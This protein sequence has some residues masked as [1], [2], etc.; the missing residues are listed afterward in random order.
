MLR[1]SL[2]AAAMTLL[3]AGATASPALAGAQSAASRATAIVSSQPQASPT[4]GGALAYWTPA[5]LRA[6]VPDDLPSTTPGAAPSATPLPRGGAPVAIPGEPAD[7]DPGAAP[8]G[9]ALPATGPHATRWTGSPHTSPASTTGRIFFSKVDLLGQIVGDYSCSGS[10][11]VSPT[12]NLVITAGHCV[13]GGLGFTWNQNEIFIPGYVNGQAPYGVWEEQKMASLK[14]WTQ[15]DNRAADVGFVVLKPDASGRHVASVVGSNGIAWNEGVG[16]NVYDFGYPAEAPFAGQHLYYCSGTTD[17]DLDGT[18]GLGCT[19]NQGSSG[20]PWLMSFDG[21][22]G[23]VNSVNSYLYPS[24]PGSLY[25][26]WFG[27]TIGK[28]YTSVKG[29]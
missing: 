11:V 26:P 20:G 4:A 29:L 27:K 5:R 25:G 2:T 8:A 24:D 10:V 7:I 1:T 9:V 14:Q 18:I 16:A 28:L 3:A 23:L 6:A 22:H 21:V 17:W 19:M 13:H 15:F 12:K